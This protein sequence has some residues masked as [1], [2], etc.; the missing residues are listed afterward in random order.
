[1]DTWISRNNAARQIGMAIGGSV[2]GLILIVSCHDFIRTGTGRFAGL[3]L[4]FLLLFLGVLALFFGGNRT[5][6]VDPNARRIVIED[7]NRFRK[8]TS[9]NCVR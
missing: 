5:I 7:T 6:I 2:L 4:G 3:L 1:M 8:K 9:V